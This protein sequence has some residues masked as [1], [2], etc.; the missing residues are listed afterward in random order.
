[1]IPPAAH[2]APYPV[3]PPP[4]SV[5][6]GTV[7]NGGTVTFSGSGFLPFEK[8]SI[9]INYGDSDSSAAFRRQVGG[10]FVPAAAQLPRR[11]KLTVAA[12]AHGAFS[13]TL[14]LTKIG[15]AT[16]V[17]TGLTSGRTVTAHVK[18]VAPSDGDDNKPTKPGDGTALPTTGP[19]GAPLLIAVASGA[20]L[21]SFGTAILLLVRV[22]RR[23]TAVDR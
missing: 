3:E 18:V 14:R 5:S 13:I 4:A 23:R 16:L 6:D 10:G 11:A 21:V 1:M 19:G 9:N 7:S 2:A 12:D 17:A 8:I 15:N 20:G 22:R